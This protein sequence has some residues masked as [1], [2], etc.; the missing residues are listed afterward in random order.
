[1]TYRQYYFKQMMRAGR[2][3]L[4]YTRG[5]ILNRRV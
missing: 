2:A 3:L 5:F 1:M 4:V